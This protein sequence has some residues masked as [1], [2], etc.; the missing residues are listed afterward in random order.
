MYG[1]DFLNKQYRRLHS[2]RDSKLRI[3]EEG[4]EQA[5]SHSPEDIIRIDFA[6]RRIKNGQY[7]LCAACGSPIQKERLEAIPEATRCTQCAQASEIRGH[8]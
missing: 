5:L 4:G 7:G 3:M 6:F 8:A 2:R 1:S